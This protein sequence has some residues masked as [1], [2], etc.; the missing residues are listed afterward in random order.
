MATARNVTPGGALLRSSRL[1]SLPNQL[2]HP[3]QDVTSISKTA[4]TSY[5][6]LQAVV[7]P[8]SSRDR[9]DWGFKRPL[10]SRTLEKTTSPVV[11][12]KAVD[13]AEKF[14][15]FATAGDHL[16]TLKKWQALNQPLQATN[17]TPRAMSLVSSFEDGEDVTDI[18]LGDRQNT[19]PARWKFQGPWLLGMPGGRFNDYIKKD[20]RLRRDDFRSFLKSHIAQEANEAAASR[21][22]DLGKQPSSKREAAE[23]TDAEVFD[24]IRKLRHSNNRGIILNL[25]GKFLDLAP[26]VD[27]V[28]EQSNLYNTGTRYSAY[29]PPPTHPSAG[30]SYLRTANFLDNHPVYGP[31]ES[32]PP[33]AARLVTPKKLG[34]AG[35]LAEAPNTVFSPSNW[36]NAS[37]RAMFQVDAPG[38]PK[39]H[40][41]IASARIDAS[42]RVQLA[43]LEA[44]PESVVV[45]REM[46]GQ[47][48]ILKSGLGEARPATAT[49][50]NPAQSVYRTTN[51]RRTSRMGSGRAYGLGGGGSDLPPR[52]KM[53]GPAHDR[54]RK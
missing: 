12:V 47:T 40:V 23:V 42:G 14:T 2:R 10:P 18:E 49:L 44:R 45:Q 17:T 43:L 9:G 39:Q 37:R 22:L 34:V 50:A 51:P 41:A 16:I 31:Q 46:E 24:Y 28:L 3:S 6:L 29:G 33:I 30:L 38:G 54:M 35:V 20:V 48:S 27:D 7:A 25:V 32:H 19:A 8:K 5:P 53:Y 1:F 21:A 52:P 15:D 26:V 36:H 11:R 4:T 13:S